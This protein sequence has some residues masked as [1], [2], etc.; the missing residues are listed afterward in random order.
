MPLGGIVNPILLKKE[1]EDNDP[2]LAEKIA[3]ASNQDMTVKTI[4]SL[5]E[6][7]KNTPKKLKIICDWDEVIQ[8]CEPYAL[9][10]AKKQ[11]KDF[12]FSFVFSEG[13]N[14]F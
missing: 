11:S 1:T 6:I 5:Y 2:N 14:D 3:E 8:P 4:K 9:Y 13:F 12:T 10:L 7:Y